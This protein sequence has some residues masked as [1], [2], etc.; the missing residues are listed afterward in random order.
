MS[1]YF[2]QGE[3]LSFWLSRSAWSL[4][5]IT[6]ERRKVKTQGIINILVPD[7]FCNESLNILRLIDCKIIFYP[8]LENLNNKNL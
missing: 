3:G 7:Y 2:H 6:N 5:I 8:I 1:K 4:A